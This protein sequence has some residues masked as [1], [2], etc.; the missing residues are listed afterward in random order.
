M[1]SSHRRSFRGLM[2]AVGLFPTTVG[3]QTVAQSFD[4]L[5]RMLKVDQTVFVTDETGRLTKGKVAD[6]SASS[7]T[8]LAPA[9][10]IFGEGTVTRINR[11]DAVW[12]G[13]LI[14]LGV[15]AIP[16]AWLGTVYCDECQ[17]RTGPVLIGV[18]LFS[19]IGAAIG[20]GIDV[21]ADK[22][23]RL[24]YRSRQRPAQ[25]QQRTG[26]LVSSLISENRQSILVSV[27]F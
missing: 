10:R 23:G 18:L 6:L 5:Q 13:A 3:A 19:G 12:N 27:R 8:L 7:L 17:H 1:I 22:V 11:A 2:A 4:E 24:V 14:G 26:V 16:G 20:A 9:K 21:S 25:S 15:G